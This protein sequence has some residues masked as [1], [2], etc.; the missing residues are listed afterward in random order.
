ME[1]SWKEGLQRVGEDP[2]L[3][4]S[5]DA[6]VSY[7]PTSAAAHTTLTKTLLLYRSDLLRPPDSVRRKHGHL[8]SWSAYVAMASLRQSKAKPIC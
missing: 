7:A 8:T 5:L 4:P 6:D 2:A 3:A 1:Q